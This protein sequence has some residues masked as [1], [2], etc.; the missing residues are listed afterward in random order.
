M[1]KKAL[2]LAAMLALA[3]AVTAGEPVAP[4]AEQ[5][6]PAPDVSAS[7]QATTEAVSLDWLKPFLL[8]NKSE[9]MLGE[10]VFLK[11][12][13]A[14]WSPK[15]R[16]DIEGHLHPSND[17][18]IE[19]ARVGELPKRYFGIGKKDVLL[20]QVSL[21]LPRGQM[22][23]LRWLLCHDPDKKNGFLFDQP[24][25]YT[26]SSQ[27]RM[28]INKMTVTLTLPP[29]GGPPIEIVVTSPTLSEK[30]VLDQ[31]MRPE[32]AQDLHRMRAGESTVKVWEDIAQRYPQSVWAP[33]AKLMLL[34]RDAESA[35]SK[36]EAVMAQLEA[37]V[38]DYPDF[39][40]R[41]D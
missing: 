17:M 30:P 27:A 31:M 23:S 14:N 19:V 4:P 24:G 37:I 3:S 39:P 40:M 25:H 11:L 13:V 16:F 35:S 22:A 2:A 6:S 8:T 41:D 34:R 33:Y 36:P 20:P 28:T 26:I 15:H 5:A 18:Q 12:V 1:V 38:K 29:P 7:E 10:P 32:C 21:P 9:Y